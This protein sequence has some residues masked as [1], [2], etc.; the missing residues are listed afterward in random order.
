MLFDFATPV[1]A[2][3]N[4]ANTYDKVTI[5]Y[6]FLATPAAATFYVDDVFFGGNVVVP[7]PPAKAQLALPITWNDT[8]NVN[9]TVTDFDGTSS[10]LA[11]DPMNAN[12]IVLKTDKSATGQPWQGT[13]LS[14]PA[15]LASAI[16]FAQGATTISAVVYSPDT[17]V[18]VRLKVEDSSNPN[19]NAEVDVTTTV[20]GG[21]D[22]LLFD[23]AT[24]VA[25]ALNFANTYDK[26]TIFYGF[27]AT[28]AAAT[29][30][31]DDVFFG[32]PTPPACIRPAITLDTIYSCNSI[33]IRALAPTASSHMWNDNYTSDLREMLLSNGDIQQYTVFA[34]NQQG[35]SSD[36]LDVVF[37]ATRFDEYYTLVA[38]DYIELNRKNRVNTGGIGVLKNNNGK[39]KLLKAAGVNSPEGFVIA[40]KVV[41]SSSALVSNVK[42]K[43]AAIINDAVFMSNNNNQASSGTRTVGVNQ[44]TTIN[45]DNKNI[46]IKAFSDVTLIAN[47]YQDITVMKGAKVTFN[48][49]NVNVKSITLQNGRNKNSKTT[50]AFNGSTNLMVKDGISVGSFAEINPTNEDVFIYSEDDVDVVTNNT[51]INANIYVQGGNFTTA[52]S[53]SKWSNIS[54]QVIADSILADGKKTNWNWNMCSFTGPASPFVKTTEVKSDDSQSITEVI[55][56]EIQ[57]RVYPNPSNGNFTLEAITDLAKDFNLEIYNMNGQLVYSQIFGNATIIRENL[58]IESF[59]KGLYFL[60]LKGDNFNEQLKLVIQ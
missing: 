32:S 50:L 8:A 28:P 19:I 20:A 36:T 25:A 49:S 34:T 39:V 52:G 43:K 5:F 33:H 44:T 16:P 1:A 59:A 21:W 14:T 60:N 10:M 24:P 45:A 58:N 38:E 6:G 11:A 9:Y 41:A 48:R 2:A 13:T 30:Y 27:L 29:Y 26:V 37:N 22:T 18:V 54:G 46:V 42:L 17:G 51:D 35:C 12:N 55:S 7:P 3:L 56:N 23:F 4:F 31:V 47:N 57:F 40:E 53:G 15:G